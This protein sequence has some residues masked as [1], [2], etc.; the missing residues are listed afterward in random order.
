MGHGV[1]VGTSHG[2]TAG[3]SQRLLRATRSF[4]EV[5]VRTFTGAGTAEGEA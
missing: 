1:T 2:V 3:I 5:M 4:A